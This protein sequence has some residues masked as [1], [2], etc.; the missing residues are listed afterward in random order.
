VIETLHGSSILIFTSYFSFSK[1][2]LNA[3]FSNSY[4]LCA[5]VHTYTHVHVH[6]YVYIIFTQMQDDPI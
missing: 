6:V 4:E 3:L 1:T 2:F 5:D